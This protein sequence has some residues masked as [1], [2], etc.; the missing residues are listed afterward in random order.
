M[1]M[2]MQIIFLVQADDNPTKTC[3][4]LYDSVERESGHP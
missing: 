2:A 1:V 4:C 3:G